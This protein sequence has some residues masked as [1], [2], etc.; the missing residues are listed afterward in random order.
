MRLIFL[1]QL[2]FLTLGCSNTPTVE[3]SLKVNFYEL[4]QQ[5]VGV[6]KEEETGLLNKVSGEFSTDEINIVEFNSR[7]SLPFYTIVFGMS[8]PYP[9]GPL[10]LCYA[11]KETKK[12][13]YIHYSSSLGRVVEKDLGIGLL[14]KELEQIYDEEEQQ[15]SKVLTEVFSIRN[16]G[17]ELKPV[18]FD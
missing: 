2:L 8:E 6:H 18:S 10:G 12:V 14:K 13:I 5:C 1:T 9:D 15:S 4:F 3:S 16:S 7:E 11:H 17:L